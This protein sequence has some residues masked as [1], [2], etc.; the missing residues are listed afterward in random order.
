LR[1]ATAD[2][3]RAKDE[4]VRIPATAVGVFRSLNI[5]GGI[6]EME[7]SVDTRDFAQLEAIE[8]SELKILVL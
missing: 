7:R 6:D 4:K 5:Q 2:K 1:R 3:L 8:G